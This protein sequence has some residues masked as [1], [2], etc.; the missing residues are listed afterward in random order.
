MPPMDPNQ[1]IS[2]GMKSINNQTLKIAR[3]LISTNDM[4]LIRTFPDH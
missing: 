2:Q 3:V 1:Y 4:M